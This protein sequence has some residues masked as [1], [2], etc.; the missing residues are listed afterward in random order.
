M[1]SEAKLYVVTGPSGTGIKEIIGAVLDQRADVTQVVPLT[2]RKRKPGEQ[3][4]E[5]Y[6]FYDLEQ[7]NALKESGDLL[8]AIEF[9]G[10]DYGTSRRLVNEQLAQGKN[11]LLYLDLP[12]AAQVKQ[13]MPESVS[14]YMAPEDPAAL[15]AAVERISHTAFEARYRMEAAKE[16]AAQAVFCDL[17]IPTDDPGLAEKQLSVLIR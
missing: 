9:A 12:R 2:A 5:N 4:G 17:R 1:A 3:N 11:V 10:N 14:I 16:Q 6:W 15:Q 8:E 13:S 7:W